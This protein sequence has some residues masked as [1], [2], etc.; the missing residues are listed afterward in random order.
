METGLIMLALFVTTPWPLFYEKGMKTWEIRSYPIDYRGPIILVNSKNNTVICQMQ[1][2]DCIP[3]NRERWEMN[4]EK[5]RTSC[6]YDSLPYRKNDSP[7]YA[8]VLS[9]PIKYS[10]PVKIDRFDKKPYIYVDSSM[11]ESKGSSPIIFKSER[12]ACKFLGQTMLIYWLKK[13]Y[14]A[15][16]AVSNTQTGETQ[17]VTDEISEE[18]LSYLIT[19]LNAK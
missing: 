18:E 13:Q 11:F 15:L 2:D 3:L 17:L 1:L 16:V 14:F 6:D 9:S 4:F 10:E 7:A 5:H 19:Q 12:L 8:W